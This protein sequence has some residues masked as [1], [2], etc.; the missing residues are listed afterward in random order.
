MRI[1]KIIENGAV[2]STKE[3][4]EIANKITEAIKADALDYYMH[5]PYRINID[6]DNEGRYFTAWIPDIG[7][8]NVFGYGITKEEALKNLEVSKI[9]WF[10]KCLNSG[11]EIPEPKK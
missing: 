1:Q 6:Y 5:L 11:I 3:K 4:N 8:D 9:E 10:S 2:Y 7:R